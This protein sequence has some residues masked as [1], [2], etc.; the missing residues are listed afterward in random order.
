MEML[1]GKQAKGAAAVEQHPPLGSRE[2]AAAYRSRGVELMHQKR[3]AEAEQDLREALRLE[4]AD[5]DILNDFGMA[6]WRQKRF[7]E[8]ETSFRQAFLINPNHYKTLANLGLALQDQR[9]LDEAAAAY[10]AALAIEPKGFEALTNMG[11]ILSNEGKLDEAM[12]WLLSAH[13]VSP[14]SWIG[15]QNLG[16]NLCRLGRWDEAVVMYE[17]ALKYRPETPELHRNLAY[18]LLARGD[19]ERGWIEHEWRFKCDDHVGRRVNRTFWNGGDFRGRSILLHSEQG[20]GDTLQ[21]IRYAA[22]VK[23]RGGRV[24]VLCPAPLL[25]L[26]A[27]CAGV[28]MTVDG[29][30]FVPDCHIHAPMMSLPVIFGTTLETIPACV[31][32]LSTEPI[33]V[34]YWRRSLEQALGVEGDRSGNAVESAMPAATARPF[35]I[36]IA[37]Q[38][39]PAHSADHWRSIPLSHFARLAELP[40][41][42][43]VSLQTE[44]GLDQLQ[45]CSGRFRVTELNGPR[46]D[47]F[48]ATAAIVSQLDLVIAPDTAVVHLAGGLEVPV[49]VGISS[50]NDWRWGHVREDTPWYPTV[51]LFRQTRLGDWDGVFQ[52]MRTALEQELLHWSERSAHC[53]RMAVI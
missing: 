11:V 37:W 24:I 38:G 20:Y 4:P 31:P 7:T 50:A 40:G 45:A 10:R 41:V 17:E 12:G 49:W 43:L 23:R 3:Y 29:S 52:R 34:E 36:G 6:L 35:L 5:V 26:V 1:D 53:S 13:L 14:Q 51:R 22:L 25:R 28:D 42:R 46:R 30:S 8:A 44:H 48:T 9:R 19:Y 16:M 2:Q 47:D 32:Y 21:F 18:A 15:L 27:R 39:N 33:L